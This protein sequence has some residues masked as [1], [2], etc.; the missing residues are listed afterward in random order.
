VSGAPRL[1]DLES[2]LL[3]AGF[4]EVSITVKEESREV[5]A[6][7]MPGSGA[8]NFIASAKVCAVKPLLNEATPVVQ[9]CG[10]PAATTSGEKLG[11]G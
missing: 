1:S 2:L 6:G 3:E 8:E 4:E 11:G 7:W 9:V 5:I 10:V